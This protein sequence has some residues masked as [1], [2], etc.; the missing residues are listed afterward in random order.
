MKTASASPPSRMRMGCLSL[1][2]RT[3]TIPVV[4]ILLC[5]LFVA[6]EM[7]R[8]VNERHHLPGNLKDLLK[9]VD[10]LKQIST[11]TS[12]REEDDAIPT[13]KP[14][15]KRRI[16]ELGDILKDLPKLRN[17]DEERQPKKEVKKEQ[18]EDEVI[19]SEKVTKEE[20]YLQEEK[21]EEEEEMENEDQEEE[22]EEE[23]E[24]T[25][26]Y[27]Q[28]L[29]ATTEKE[30][31]RLKENDKKEKRKEESTEEVTFV[32]AAFNINRTAHLGKSGKAYKFEEDYIGHINWFLDFL[33]P[34]P[35]HVIVEKRYAHLIE[36]HLHS[37]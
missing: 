26:P 36:P 35:T 30:K 7:G 12:E 24:G 33:A 37:R 18:L 10:Q 23:K 16:R 11:S 17:M 29:K 21:G 5:F 4:L 6:F 31:E 19:G 34:L 20:D 28:E 32:L 14:A 2:S 3:I 22:E 25:S 9:T 13:P 15:G 27:E 1:S 8:S